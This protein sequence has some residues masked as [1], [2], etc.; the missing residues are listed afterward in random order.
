MFG[1][2]TRTGAARN[3]SLCH[4]SG[5]WV[6]WLDADEYLDETNRQKLAALAAALPEANVAYVMKQRSH[7]AAG[8]AAT[9]V[10]HNSGRC[11]TG[12]ISRCYGNWCPLPSEGIAFV[13]C[14]WGDPDAEVSDV[15][16]G[17]FSRSRPP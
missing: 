12:C 1:M 11:W 17:A 10:D 5:D 2:R 9:S 14:S 13:S 4:A 16:S 8:P 6:F 3:E 7:A 15:I